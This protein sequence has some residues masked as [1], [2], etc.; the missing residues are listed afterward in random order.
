MKTKE[1]KL[2]GLIKIGD[3]KSFKIFRK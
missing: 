2:G 3:M 1:E